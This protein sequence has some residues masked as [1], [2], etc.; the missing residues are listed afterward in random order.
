MPYCFVDHTGDTAVKV[1][2][3]ADS[4]LFQD[5]ARALSAIIV[6]VDRA[7][8][9]G[10]SE[11]RLDLD[12]EDG[13]ALL[14]DFLNELIFMFD[15]RRFLPW[16]LT[17]EELVIGVPARLRGTVRGET[18]DP[19]CHV[20]LTEVKAATFH[21]VEIRQTKEGWETTIVFDL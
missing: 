8:P 15:S 12:A 11:Q 2:A 3:E 10:E 17:V 6:D 7:P 18:F 20:F 4:D 14:I 9:D 5:A 21:D 16:T 19:A 13:E 1:T